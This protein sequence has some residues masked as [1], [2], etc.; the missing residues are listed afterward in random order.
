MRARLIETVENFEPKFL[1]YPY[2]PF[3][4]TSV[5]QGQA[6]FCKTAI[7]GRIIAELSNGIYPPR[8]IRG[9]IKD[10]TQLTEWELYVINCDNCHK[11]TPSINLPFKRP[12]GEPIKTVYISRNTRNTD[13]IK[14]IYQ[15]FGGRDGFLK[16]NDG[17]TGLSRKLIGDAKFV[18]IDSIFPSFCDI[19]VLESETGAAFLFLNDFNISQSVFKIDLNEGIHYIESVK[20]YYAPD[21]GR[22]GILMDDLGRPEFLNYERLKKELDRK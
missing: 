11:K 13:Y 14:N 5:F 9:N 21:Y 1:W 16:V 12:L 17:L 22:I 7:I 8:L 15:M 6:E 4:S 20:N 3:E 10:R 2:I 18:V 19:K